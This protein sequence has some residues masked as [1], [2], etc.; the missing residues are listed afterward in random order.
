MT[1]P[2]ASP[3]PTLAL[4]FGTRFE[5][6]YD[7]EGLERQDGQFLAALDAADA[8]LASRLR[9]ARAAPDSLATKEEARGGKAGEAKEVATLHGM[10]LSQAK[11]RGAKARRG[12]MP[13]QASGEVRR[14]RLVRERLG[15]I[16]E[17]PHDR[18]GTRRVG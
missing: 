14:D 6:L 16:M 12:P 5:D 2:T 13:P 17:A 15:M 1:A 4:A 10:F 3:A 8:G 18:R 7:T 11:W 9:A